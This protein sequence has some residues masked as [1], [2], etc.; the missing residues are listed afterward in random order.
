[1]RLAFALYTWIECRGG[2]DTLSPAEADDE[3]KKHV[4]RSIQMFKEIGDLGKEAAASMV[5]GHLCRDGSKE[6]R[7]WYQIALEQ[8]QQA[9]GEKCKLMEL[10]ISSIGIYYEDKKNYS[11][12]YDYFLKS[13]QLCIEVLGDGHQR[14][15]LANSYLSHP[16]YRRIAK[17]KA[18]KPAK[19]S[20]PS[21]PSD[22]KKKR[23][24]KDNYGIYIYKVLKQVHP[25]TSISS[26]A[27]IIMNSFMN[28]IFE[29]I[30]VESSRLAQ[31]N[32][33][34]TISS[35]EIQTAVRLIFPR[36]LA[37]HAV[38]EGSKAVTKYTTSK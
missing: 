36:E 16:Y 34:S 9:L 11:S 17:T 15:I 30:A 23:K 38:S 37:K 28:D 7:E 2:D 13:R 18:A 31:H 19:P 25:D 27:M 35:R 1:M 8:C 12:A 4:E 20:Q 6:Q 22:G 33:K 3:P 29:Q 14:T 5:K 10:I 26:R 32:K 24:R 21:Q